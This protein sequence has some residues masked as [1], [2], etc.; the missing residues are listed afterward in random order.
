VRL[1]H[2]LSGGACTWA[3]FIGVHMGVIMRSDF[4]GFLFTAIFFCDKLETMV[5]PGA[6]FSWFFFSFE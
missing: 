4:A 3:L 5:R 2:L 1:E 6:D